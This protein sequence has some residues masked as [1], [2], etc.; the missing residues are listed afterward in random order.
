VSPIHA[1]G[2]L[3]VSSSQN[4]QDRLTISSANRQG[5]VSSDLDIVVTLIEQGK[6]VIGAPISLALVS[7]PGSDAKQKPATGLTDGKG[8]FH[9]TLHLSRLAGDHLLL[10]RSGSYSDEV[11][12]I[13][14]TEATGS[15]IKLPFGNINISSN[16]LVVWLSVGCFALILLGVLVNI[17]VMRRFVWSATGGRIF[18]W[19][20]RRLPAGHPTS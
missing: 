4:P 20:R 15:S 12:V 2:P 3:N 5:Q 13:G 8:Q 16:P 6:P 1:G 9:S 7:A 11:H 18:H 19:L 14:Q 10:A 17:N